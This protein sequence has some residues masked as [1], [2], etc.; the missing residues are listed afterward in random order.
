M[1]GEADRERQGLLPE[2]ARVGLRRERR[3]VAQVSHTAQGRVD[4]AAAD[5]PSSNG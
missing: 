1:L 4:E 3:H 2:D 5:K